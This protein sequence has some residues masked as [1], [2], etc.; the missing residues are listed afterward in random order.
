MFE[1]G[2]GGRKK[3]AIRQAPFLASGRAGQKGG[4]YIINDK[5]KGNVKIAGETPALR[6]QMQKLRAN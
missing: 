6:I 2:R 5:N 3:T 1:A 4:R